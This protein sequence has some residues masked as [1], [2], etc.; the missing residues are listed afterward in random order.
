MIYCPLM[1]FQRQSSH[2]QVQCMNRECGFADE[3]GSCLIKQA[4]QC[5]VAKE[6]TRVA[7]EETAEQM[8]KQSASPTSE[9]MYALT[10]YYKKKQITIDDCFWE[11]K[12]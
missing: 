1:S 2:G 5:Y 8:L 7:L 11:R 10:D 4:L 9:Y 12:E 6:R 3:A